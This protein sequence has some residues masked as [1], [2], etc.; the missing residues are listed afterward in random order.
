MQGRL[1]QGDGLTL[2]L[3]WGRLALQLAGLQ[4][5]AQLHADDIYL[6]LTVLQHLLGCQQQLPVLMAETGRE[7]KTGQVGAWP[8]VLVS[9][10][11][12]LW[13]T[14]HSCVGVKECVPGY[15]REMEPWHV[16]PDSCHL[17][18]VWLWTSCSTALGL[19]AHLREG[20]STNS[21]NHHWAED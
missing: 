1:S 13:V 10:P 4:C 19:S 17:T 14:E 6:G 3:V 8:P 16:N 15:W 5:P 18:A 20:E 9:T 21:T 2:S 12:R 7:G 11:G